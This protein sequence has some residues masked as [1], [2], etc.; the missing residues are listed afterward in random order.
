MATSSQLIQCLRG[1]YEADNRETGIAN[2]LGR[3]YRHVTFL[4]GTEDLLRGLLERAPIHHDRAI[5][6][7]KE[8]A[9]FRKDKTLVYCALLLVGRGGGDKRLPA[10]LCAPLFFFPATVVEDES[11]AFVTVDL[12]QQRV[13]FPVLA[14]L[15]GQNEAGGA[16]VEDLL[17]E[18]PRAP[19]TPD[20]IHGLM[21][22]LMDVLTGVDSMPL[23]GYPQLADEEQVRQAV[24][25]DGEK[26]S[27]PI[28][29]LPAA[30]LAL[31][32]TSPETR[33]VLAELGE[34]AA[35][36][37]LSLPVR[38]LLNEPDAAPSRCATVASGRVP[39]VL[40]RA[41][42]EVLRASSSAPL[43]LVVGPPGT[44]KSYT[45]AA[46]A[47]D[48][49]SRGQSVL[50]ASRMDQAVNVVADKLAALLG[51]S[52]CVIRAGR[53][54]HLRD[55]KKSLEQMLHGIKRALLA[56]APDPRRVQR[57][58]ARVE[59]DLAWLER[60]LG[61]QSRREEQW[62]LT[63]TS[64]APDGWFG[65]IRHT[66]QL[67]KLNW[68]IG[69][70]PPLWDLTHQYQ[71]ALEQRGQLVAELLQET[72]A[73]R[74]RDMLQRHRAELS[75]F[76][77]SLKARTN[78]KQE[79][80]FAAVRRDVLFG[81]F[82][83]WLVTLAD[84][85][86]VL[87]LEP[88]LFDLAIID[89]ATQCDIASSLPVLQR[90]RRAVIV[91]DPNQ[92]RHVSFLSDQRQR[93]LAE[94]CGLDDVQ[95]ERFHY[96]RKSILD[97]L[98]E[99]VATQQQ[100]LFLDE[101]FR[102]MPQIIGF[103]NREFYAGSLKVMTQRPA[104][105]AR[106]CVELRR[107]AGRNDHGT[108]REEAQALVTEVLRRVKAEDR[109][110]AEACHSLGV[111]SPF[112]DQVDHIL[113]LLQKKLSLEALGKH[114]LLVGT[115]HSFQGE[116]RDVMYL[117]LVVDPASHPASF[118]FLS[119]PNVFNVSIT[120]ARDEQIVFASVRPEDVKPDTLLRRYL[121]YIA[122]GPEAQ[123]TLQPG[124]HD[125]FLQE[126]CSELKQLDFAIWPA[127]PAAGM[128]I[129][130]VI[131]RDGRTLGIDL[132]GYPGPLAGALDLERYR[133][134]QRAGLTL[135]P[136]SYRSWLRDR[137]GCLQAIERWHGSE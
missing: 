26:D 47:L 55:L 127:W 48:H 7:Q 123:E 37:R 92:L 14:A 38:L 60:R 12:S 5:A 131:E 79:Q 44:G 112:R 46:L 114:D 134:F 125:E 136:L 99:T 66:W 74:I 117:S 43:S 18:L 65:R 56:E 106:Q 122:A 93:T 49:L 73:A 118:Q 133:M 130:L 4:E 45:I 100:V 52:P 81:T 103:S 77:Q 132:I 137:H 86:E 27:Q 135:F 87:P 68:Q 19:F 57:Q 35:A 67:R 33:G 59:G 98:S 96:R 58:L 13:N 30:A 83:I 85:A 129:D 120:R 102:S 109:L 39:A 84:V 23:A 107:V 70:A 78:L 116:E 94:P 20:K 22:L 75:K 88:E 76:L 50:V 28:R 40:S 36:A 63:M 80:L 97:L 8:A 124:R 62:G 95:Q 31:I 29:C 69:T 15:A 51:P 53:G 104:T 64:P 91:G 32:P 108:N 115:A 21:S 42:Q 82:P 105:A 10:R 111:L 126:V 110:P 2:L 113:A 101:H 16:S 54:E 90:A 1:C 72:V 61:T 3:K 41:Q 89:E 71:R 119:N 17:A 128:T 121:D 6:A 34:M 25:S 24:K 11:A 9:L